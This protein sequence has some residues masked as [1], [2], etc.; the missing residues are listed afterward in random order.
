M[1]S[2][3]NFYDRNFPSLVKELHYA[4]YTKGGVGLTT[5]LTSYVIGPL[6]KFD[7][8]ITSYEGISKKRREELS[9]T[10][11]SYQ[12]RTNADIPLDNVIFYKNKQYFIVKKRTFENLSSH[13]NY[14]IYDK[15]V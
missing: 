3:E 5:G 8:H 14:L 11:F 10:S 15:R 6:V 9:D 1:Q 4:S 13:F 2:L 7:G 12:I